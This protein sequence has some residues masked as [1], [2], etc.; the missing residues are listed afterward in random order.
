MYSPATSPSR[1][2]YMYM[3]MSNMYPTPNR[4]SPFPSTGLHPSQANSSYTNKASTSR[5][6]PQLPLTLPNHNKTFPYHTLPLPY[7]TPPLPYHTPPLPY[8][9]PPELQSSQVHPCQPSTTLGDTKCPPIKP[10]K[11]TNTLPS[12]DI[13]NELLI[14]PTQG[15]IKYHKL[16]KISK[17]STL[18]TK[19]VR[20]SFF[21]EDVS[22][23]CTVMGC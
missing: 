20:D 21:A 2:M 13:I 7:H 3:Y 11:N 5:Q 18:A 14:P 10:K 12:A 15:C 8:K 23:H 6:C 22:G 1:Y 9:S 16:L 4:S 17:A 19:L